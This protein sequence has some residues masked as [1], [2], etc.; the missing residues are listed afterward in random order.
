MTCPRRLTTIAVAGLLALGLSACGQ[1]EAAA[2]QGPASTAPAAPAASA[3]S[4]GPAATASSVPAVAPSSADGATSAPTPSATS[5]APSSAP[6]SAGSP[7]AS[8]A[9]PSQWTQW[10]LTTAGWG[11]V[12]LG[13]VVPATLRGS[14]KPGWECVGP[15]FKGDGKEVVQI[16]AGEN[17]LDQP[18]NTIALESPR[19]S[20]ASGLAIG[21]STA[22]LKQLYPKLEQRNSYQSTDGQQRDVFELA[23]GKYSMFFEMK[24][25]KVVHISVQ[26]AANFQPMGLVGPCGAP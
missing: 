21:D 2:P 4:S 5:A 9:D 22:K 19:L 10:K 26:P 6:S 13:Q 23:D 20:T 25:S 11:P 8:V 16:F 7:S 14:F 12:K 3:T 1:E 18:V 24:G 17:K 15:K